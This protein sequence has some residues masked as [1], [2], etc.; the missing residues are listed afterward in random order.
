MDGEN[1]KTALNERLK[2]TYILLI[3]NFVPRNCEKALPALQRNA[4]GPLNTNAF[5]SSLI[6][7]PAT[8][9]S[10]STAIPNVNKPKKRVIIIFNHQNVLL[11]TEKKYFSY[12][13][14]Y[15]PPKI[16][17]MRRG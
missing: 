6:T 14:K 13:I 16:D 15:K 3:A 11:A 12:S 9:S 7:T 5:D 2:M 8:T 17:C 1:R 4:N 10:E